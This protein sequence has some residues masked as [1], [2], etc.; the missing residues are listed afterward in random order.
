MIKFLRAKLIRNSLP[1]LL[2]YPNNVSFKKAKT[3]EEYYSCFKLLHD[4]YVDCGYMEKND[5]SSRIIPN[6]YDP[7]TKVCMAY[8]EISSDVIFTG[9][10]FIDYKFGLPLDSLFNY[11]LNELRNKGKRIAEIGCL[12]SNKLYRKNNKLI[13]LYMNRFIFNECMKLNVDELIVGIHPKHVK[14]YEDLLLFKKIGYSKSYSYVNNNVC[15]CLRLN[16]NTIKDKMK[17]VYN[18]KPLEKNLYQFYF[19]D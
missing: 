15:V 16:L 8:D 4:I 11:E 1:N 9:S 12:A 5:Q 3:K 13:P 2:D 14:I 17:K 7:L 18:K 10:I 6:H 19:K